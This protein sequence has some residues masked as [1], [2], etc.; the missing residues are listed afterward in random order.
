MELPGDFAGE[1]VFYDID[2]GRKKSIARSVE[3]SPIRY[4][5]LRSMA[6]RFAD[7]GND[8][9]P[10]GAYNTDTGSKKTME[11]HC[12]DNRRFYASSFQST[13]PRFGRPWSQPVTD[14]IY[15]VQTTSNAHPSTLSRSVEVTPLHYA[16]HHSKQKRF[17]D[18]SLSE[19]PDVVY[20]LDRGSKQTL[21]TSMLQSP[22]TYRNMGTNSNK[23]E[24]TRVDEAKLNLGPGSYDYPYSGDA[25]YPPLLENRPL[26]SLQSRTPRFGAGKSAG[27]GLGSTYRPENDTK[28]WHKGSKTISKAEYLRPQYLPKVYMR[29]QMEDNAAAAAA[30]HGREK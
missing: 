26:S 12:R 3:T 25:T 22:I 18:K 7:H 11:S 4:S 29:K 1:P 9:V 16:I 19:A 8:K 24:A 14:H 15:D 6:P 21:Y 30:A 27:L 17:S 5:I 20:D 28:E 13:V 10:F 23:F 2:N